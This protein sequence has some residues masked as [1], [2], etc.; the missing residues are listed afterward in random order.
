ML[1][2]VV[3]VAVGD[4]VVGPRKRPLNI[5]KV[6]GLQASMAE[7]GLLQPIVI[8]ER[9]GL[10]A[11]RHRLEAARRLGWGSVAARIAPLDGL[12]AELAEIDENLMRNE[13]TV[14]EQGEHLLRRSEILEALGE[15]A[16]HGGQAGN[17][18]AA[19]NEGD[20]VSP[21][22]SPK[23]TAVIA[24]EIGLGER[25]AQRRLQIARDLDGEVKEAIAA[26]PI[27][28]RTREMLDLSRLEPEEQRR[29]VA[30][31][32][33]KEGRTSV[34]QARRAL[35]A[36]DRQEAPVL[37]T[38]KFRVIYADPP[39][40]YGNTMPDYMGVQDDHYPVMKLR[41]IAELPVR[42]M[43][44]DDAVLFLWVTSPILEESFDVVRGW[45][46]RYKAS[47]VWDKVR[48]VMGH[49]NS[50]RHELLL[51]CTRGSCLPDV[52]RLFDSV[53]S[54]ERGKHSQ[55]PEEFRDIIDTIY[56][57]GRRIELFARRPSEGWEVWG[58]ESG[59]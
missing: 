2:Q 58:N 43:T 5:E 3:V 55:K 49:Y 18:N 28:N 46:F 56:P 50:V 30:V 40:S 34:R 10:V 14:L 9:Y 59:C 38:D 45:G 35:T 36:R 24:G 53:Q 33:V 54:I 48:H 20:T 42:D 22:F 51:V 57:Y 39:W 21:S 4:V 12:R 29:V 31:E 37:P 8:T 6:A 44:A 47:F 32:G 23:T 1:E 26:E 17:R 15:R 7:V 27:A 16:S 52:A 41:E 25:S 11:G 13:L 19:R